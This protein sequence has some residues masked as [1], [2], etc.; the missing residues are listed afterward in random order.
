[1]NGFSILMFIFAISVF[2]VGLYMF[3]GHKIDMLS[4]RAPYQ[5]LNADDWKKIGKYTMIVSMFIFI[6]GI[7]V[8]IFNIQ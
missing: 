1:M 3:T 4:W 8:L 7:I 2:L 5:N 6:I